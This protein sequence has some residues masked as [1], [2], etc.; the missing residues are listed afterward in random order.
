MYYTYDGNGNLAAEQ[1]GSPAATTAN[2]ALVSE[3]N[4]IYSTDYGFALIHPDTQTE[5]KN[6]YRRNYQ[7]NER[8]QLVRSVDNQY[9]V[10]Y[11]YGAD[12]NRANKFAR[13]TGFATET[14]YFNRMY[15]VNRENTKDAWVES[16]HIFVGDTRIV[17][18]RTD[19]G[20]DDYG[21]EKEEQYFYHGD[22]LGSAQ[23]VTG[24]DGRVYE[25]LEYTPYGELWVEHAEQD[26][27]S[28][29]KTV[30]RFTGKER[31]GE[32]GLYYYGARYLNPQTGL[33]LSTDPAMG[34]YVPQAPINDE[35]KKANGN[36]PGMGGVF[37]TV[38][39]HLY[40]YAG[41]NPVKYVDPDGRLD[42]EGAVQHEQNA[43]EWQRR[44]IED[45][46]TGKIGTFT[47]GQWAT[48]PGLGEGF[49]KYACAATT[50]LNAVARAYTLESGKE[51]SFEIGAQIMLSTVRGAKKIDEGGW[52]KSMP[53]ALEHMAQKAGIRGR[54]WYV[55]NGT[56][57]MWK[58]YTWLR[59][60]ALDEN[61]VEKLD[62]YGNNIELTHFINGTGNGNVFDVYDGVVKSLNSRSLTTMR[63]TRGI[64]YYL[65]YQPNR[66]SQ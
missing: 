19:E 14:L 1:F 39:L 22:H 32:T 41:N 25:H 59:G 47:Q 8:N 63:N 9:T 38:N 48:V 50:L 15:Q 4:G 10:E 7:W 34:E 11:R 6:V 5:E 13:R 51:M 60:Y 12:G 29:D 16:K 2:N 27:A 17:T 37:N 65:P 3:E 57:E 58:I 56:N 46:K 21:Q 33:W 23:M 66:R 55:D 54:I 40:H 42:I 52:V 24:C 62:E 30:F 44:R 31:D 61:G 18:K 36:L 45:I 20:N 53:E 49:A 64:N 26:K 35:A 43:Q 28:V